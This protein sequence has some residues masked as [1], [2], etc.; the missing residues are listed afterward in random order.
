MDTITKTTLAERLFRSHL[1]K[2]TNP[3]MTRE[4]YADL[5]TEDAV[6]QYPFAPA[7][8]AKEVLGRDAI[9]EYIS[10]VV[11]GA[12]DWDFRNFEFSTTSDPETIFVEFEG[13]ANVI[14]TGKSY[15]QLY[16]GR[17]TLKEGKISCYRE[18]WNPMWIMDAFM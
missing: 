17:V 9:T 4:A 1:A 13:S 14:A 7:P 5:F 15:R 12:T 10:N 3:D 11:N 2:F 18:F 8:Y 6:Q 16:I